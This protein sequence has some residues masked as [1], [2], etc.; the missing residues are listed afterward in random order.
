MSL[1][2]TQVRFICES[3]VDDTAKSIDEIIGIASPKL[4]PIG[5]SYQTSKPFGRNIIP[6]EFVDQPTTEY[7]CRR[8]LAHYYTREI[9][10]ETAGLWV[11]HMNEQLAEIAPYYTQLVKSTFNSVRGLTAEDIENLYGDTDLKRLFTGDYNDK[12]DGNSTNKSTTTAD[13]YNLDSDTPQ[14]GLVSIK[15]TRDT[16]GMAYLSYARRALVDQKNDNTESHNE[17]S[18]RKANTTETIKGKS[19]GKARIE[20]MKDV[21]TTLINIERRMINELSTEFINVW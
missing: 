2:T 3:L 20:L 6:W 15:P 18:D 8:I 11:F 9:G 16:E 17:T 1:Y 21:A 5:E 19:G 10:W 13:N 12:N 14:N 7:I 4:F